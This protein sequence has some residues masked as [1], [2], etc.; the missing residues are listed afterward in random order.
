M[1]KENAKY[2]LPFVQALAEGKT[3]QMSATNGGWQDMDNEE[4][5]FEPKRY[6]IKPDK[7]LRPWLPLE[8]PVGALIRYSAASGLSNPGSMC[9][10]LGYISDADLI[11]DASM[12]TNPTHGRYTRAYA[13]ASA[14]HSIDGGVTWLPCGILEDA[15]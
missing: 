10:I 6:R 5:V 12:I 13:A 7:T 15:Q 11:Y 1:N 14:E 3:I 8:V 9:L 2:Y 4:F